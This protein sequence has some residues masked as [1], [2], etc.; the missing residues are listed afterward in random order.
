MNQKKKIK[1]KIPLRLLYT[2]KLETEGGEGGIGGGGERG[3]T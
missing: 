3:G 1:K 2:A